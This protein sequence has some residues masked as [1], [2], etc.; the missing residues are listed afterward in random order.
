MENNSDN[1]N[2]N[3]SKITTSKTI[4]VAETVE[5]P[6]KQKHKFEWTPKRK[7]AFEKCVAA[8]KCQIEPKQKLKQLKKKTI[9]RYLQQTVV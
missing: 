6:K 4:E 5:K 3:E 1:G 8:R 9:L 7:A 2:K